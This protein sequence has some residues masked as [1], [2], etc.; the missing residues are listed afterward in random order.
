MENETHSDRSKN[1]KKPLKMTAKH[2]REKCFL[3]TS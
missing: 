2:K 1:S 3:K